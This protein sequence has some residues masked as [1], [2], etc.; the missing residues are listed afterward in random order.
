FYHLNYFHPDIL[1]FPTRRSSDLSLFLAYSSA[2][3]WTAF[4]SSRSRRRKVSSRKFTLFFRESRRQ[5]SRCGNAIFRGTP[6]NPA[7]VPTSIILLTF[8]ISK[9]FT[10]DRLS[11]KCF[12]RTS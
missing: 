8:F 12:T 4:I 5:A 7:P 11:R 2:R 10:Q 1:S 6:G 9:A 3:P